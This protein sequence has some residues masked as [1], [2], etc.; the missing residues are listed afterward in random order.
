MSKAPGF[1]LD[2]FSWNSRPEGLK[3]SRKPLPCVTKTNKEKVMKQLGEIALQLLRMRFDKIGSLYEKNGEFLIGK[4][5]SHALI[6]HKRDFRD[7]KIPRGP[8]ES[9]H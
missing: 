3:L 1:S 8:F 6:W 5:L 9:D 2:V 7:D 4:C